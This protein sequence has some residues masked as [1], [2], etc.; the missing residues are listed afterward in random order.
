M[1]NK[2]II[3]LSQEK[4][5][6]Y[7]AEYENLVNIERKAV[8]EALKEA[9]AQGD[10][11]EN[12]EYDAARERQGIVEGRISELEN[13]LDNAQ[14]IESK[15]DKSD[16]TVGINSLVTFLVLEKN[17]EKSV[18]ITGS[19]DTNPFEDK[20][21]MSS[22]LAVAMIGRKPGDIIEIEAPNKYSIKIINVEHL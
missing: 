13:I 9:R 19:H 3:Y 6:E 5:D 8:Q 22:P 11:S 1:D 4:Y 14:I 18:T 7:K 17:V 15:H 10:L 21:S 20:V 12:A 2:N 16:N